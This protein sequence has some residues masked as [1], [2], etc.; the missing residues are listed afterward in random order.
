M[1]SKCQVTFVVSEPSAILFCC[2]SYY[3]YLSS[4]CTGIFLM[5]IT[6]SSPYHLF[7]GWDIFLQLSLDYKFD[8]LLFEWVL[9][10][11]S[12]SSWIFTH[13][14]GGVEQPTNDYIWRFQRLVLET[15]RKSE[16][17]RR[18]GK[19]SG[20]LTPT[21]IHMCGFSLHVWSALT[22]PLCSNIPFPWASPIP[23]KK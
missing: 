6:W 13:S 22:L 10:I 12:F 8:T 5:L 23:P 3:K 7:N 2:K 18:R 16:R 9:I 15:V 11:N 19:R 14:T 4:K 17:P 1:K 21:P 20:R